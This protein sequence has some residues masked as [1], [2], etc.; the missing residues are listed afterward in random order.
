MDKNILISYISQG[1]STW[2]I[3]E[4]CNTTQPNVRYWLKKHNLKTQRT[5]ND[6]AN[7]KL[8]P[9]CSIVKSRDD[10]YSSSKK[11]SSYCKSCI[12]DANRER[13]RDNKQKSID[14]LGGECTEC[15]YNKC[16]AA[17]DIHHVDPSTKEHS[18]AHLMRSTFDKL[19]LELDKCV[20][21]CANCH[22]EHH[23]S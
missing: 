22:R 15:G 13:S 8:C 5:T 2:K 19:K 1:L 18:P 17:L 6:L 3:A 11:N 23:S 16:N 14:Y 12:K 20:L 10:F 7:D 9:S 4:T 21:L